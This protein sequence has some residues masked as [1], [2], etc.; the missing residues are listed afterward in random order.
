MAL[1][2]GR[3]GVAPSQVDEFGVIKG[4][5][6]GP[7][8]DAYTKQESDAK[9]LAKTDAASTYA[10]KSELN[11]AVDN[12]NAEFDGWTQP[13]TKITGDTSVSFDNLSDE[14][15]YSLYAETQDGSLITVSACEKEEGTTAG[16]VKLTYTLDA[17][18]STQSPVSL[19]LRILK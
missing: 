4:V 11:T 6:P 1:K 5:G 16:T 14:N 18:L 3:V 13:V 12:L 7:S 17:I 19:K 9:F 8:G 15:A 10:T 2:A